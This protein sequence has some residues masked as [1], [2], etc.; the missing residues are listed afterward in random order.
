MFCFGDSI[1]ICTVSVLTATIDILL[2]WIAASI[3]F[4]QNITVFENDKIFFQRKWNCIS[5]VMVSMFAFS[6]V[7]N[8]FEVDLVK[9]K[10]IKLVLAV[11]PHSF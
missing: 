11:S 9:P 8:G 7:D 10:I 4:I 2:K 3:I 5:G 1:T 6:A